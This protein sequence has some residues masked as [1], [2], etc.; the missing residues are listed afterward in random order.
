MVQAGDGVLSWQE[1]VPSWP[2]RPAWWSSERLRLLEEYTRRADDRRRRGDL[3]GAVSLWEE[4]LR[5]LPDMPQP[6]RVQ[7]I[8]EI[9]HALLQAARMAINGAAPDRAGARRA[10][11][12][13]LEHAART[14]C[15]D[16]VLLP[17][18]ILV[19]VSGDPAGALGWYERAVRAGAAAAP[20]GYA[21]RL[22][23][24]QVA[25]ERG[26]WRSSGVM[27]GGWG[28]AA[29]EPFAAGAGWDRHPL[30]AAAWRRLAALGA[31]AAGDVPGALSRFPGPGHEGL[32]ARWAME[33]ALIAAL[34]GEWPACLAYCRRA[35]EL[36]AAV[37]GEP[38]VYV[39]AA[40][41]LRTDAGRGQGAPFPVAALRDRAPRH[42]FADDA[43]YR[44]WRRQLV[45]W[46]CRWWLARAR[47]AIE[48]GDDRAV[49]E[50]L[51]AAV[52][53]MPGTRLARAI[54]VWVACA[55]GGVPP[56]KAA[57]A[58]LV[59]GDVSPAYLRLAAWAWE[60][61]GGPADVVRELSRLL[62]R[63][64]QD[65]WGLARWKQWMTRLGEQAMAQGRYRQ[66]LLQFASLLLYLPDDA[67][68]WRWCGRIHA[69]LGDKKRARD[70]F[71]QANRSGSM[72]GRRAQARMARM[73][74]PATGTSRAS[75]APATSPA[76]VAPGFRIAGGGEPPEYGILAALIDAAAAAPLPAAAPCAF[77]PS[78]LLQAVWASVRAPDAYLEFLIE[79]WARNPVSLASAG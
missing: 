12:R 53:L 70:C 67:D 39:F 40:A 50:S 56:A 26:D 5:R 30:A 15:D 54:D 2:A 45:R 52:G 47:E 38:Y 41:W 25:A 71:A 51:A 23:Q 61:F 75:A 73:A 68:G 48:R 36:G 29:C 66:A 78:A 27:A 35:Q 16:A 18:G 22:A 43:Q 63:C 77:S 9:H 58:E 65:A 34:A 76:A 55:Y 11:A 31:L 3:A 62:E 57:V 8:K 79:T 49:R 33:G 6:R 20:L 72:G 21:R 37:T 69:E 10:A 13:Y 1:L 14:A 4:A 7:L 59:E 44:E 60:R 46:Q 64:P 42:L 19:H 32:P 28:A 74:P 24:L 17:L